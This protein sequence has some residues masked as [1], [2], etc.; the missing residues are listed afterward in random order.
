MRLASGLRRFGPFVV[1]GQPAGVCH[2][3]VRVGGGRLSPFGVF[4]QTAIFFSGRYRYRP[5]EESRRVLWAVWAGS[6]GRPFGWR[7]SSGC[8]TRWRSTES[9]LFLCTHGEFFGCGRTRNRLQDKSRRALW[10][11][12][13]PAIAVDIHE[14]QCNWGNL[15]LRLGLPSELYLHA[16]SW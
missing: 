8:P 9:L 10:L 11:V 15:K 4:A 12:S 16:G 6:G 3:A 5:Q 7:M 13:T 14:L 1:L 2:V